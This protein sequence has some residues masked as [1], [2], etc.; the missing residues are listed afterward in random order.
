[1]SIK[2]HHRGGDYGRGDDPHGVTASGGDS[3]Q[4]IPGPV[5]Y[6]DHGGPL[7]RS[8]DSEGGRFVGRYLGR[9]GNQ[10]LFSPEATRG[11][12]SDSI[13]TTMPHVDNAEMANKGK[14][15]T[16]TKDLLKQGEMYHVK[17]VGNGNFLPEKYDEHSHGDAVG[18]PITESNPA[19]RILPGQA[20]KT[21]RVVQG[22]DHSRGVVG[23][24]L[25]YMGD[26]LF[27]SAE[28]TGGG[29]TDSLTF[30]GTMMG[31]SDDERMNQVRRFA[32]QRVV[33]TPHQ[34]GSGHTIV[35]YDRDRHKGLPGADED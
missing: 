17:N 19:N 30:P 7:A 35:P 4:S 22:R 11:G 2:Q 26:Q 21:G 25:G 23:S 3:A 14:W 12:A 10:R 24:V 5:Q 29:A 13:A 33:V 18:A 20:T 1:M 9:V 27:L 28:A 32:G 6:R 16:E 15:D 34:G 8:I 31:K